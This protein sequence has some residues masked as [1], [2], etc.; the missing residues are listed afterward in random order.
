[1]LEAA[2]EEL[3]TEA[4]A[5]ETQELG[6]LGQSTAPWSSS[7]EPTCSFSKHRLRGQIPR[8]LSKVLRETSWRVRPRLDMEQHAGSEAAQL[9]QTLKHRV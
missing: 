6:A 3:G 8:L 4:Q 7:A 9:Q 1:M 2:P 5:T